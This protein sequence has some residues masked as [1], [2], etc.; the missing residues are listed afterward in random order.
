MR[1]P[2]AGALA[3]RRQQAVRGA[4]HRRA[5]RPAR[6]ALCCGRPV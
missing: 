5:M 6:R 1:A 2:G 3:A 4:T